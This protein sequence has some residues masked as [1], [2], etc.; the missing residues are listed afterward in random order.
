[1][2]NVEKKSLKITITTG[3]KNKEVKSCYTYFYNYLV[4]NVIYMVFLRNESEH[5]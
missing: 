3:L 2:D 4:I 5:L 1:M